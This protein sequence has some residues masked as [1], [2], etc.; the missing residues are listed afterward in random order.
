LG[1]ISRVDP[2]GT[3]AYYDFDGLGSTAG[4]SGPSGSYVNSYRYLPFGEPLSTHE[5]IANPFTFTGEVGVMQD[6]NGMDFMRTRDYS[7]GQG[8]FLSEDPVGL[9]GGDAN[10]YRYVFNSSLSHRDA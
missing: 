5:T 4:L 1:L 7:S 8:R 9:N 10:A 6:A 2:S 3:A